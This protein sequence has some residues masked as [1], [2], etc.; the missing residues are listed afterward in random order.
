MTDLTT[1]S[2]RR[3]P[4]V[5]VPQ[6]ATFALHRSLYLPCFRPLS[7][8]A[9]TRPPAQRHTRPQVPV[10]DPSY[11]SQPTL[12]GNPG[13]SVDRSDFLDFLIARDERS[14]KLAG[15]TGLGGC[16]PVLEALWE[17]MTRFGCQA[18]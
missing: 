12:K 5:H 10:Q 18:C 11:G 3:K 16:D 15:R 7:L 13:A 14:Q 4:S 8:V 17:P 6:Q 2:H 9:V 1:S